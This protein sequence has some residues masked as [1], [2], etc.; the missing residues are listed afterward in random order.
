[1][2]RSNYHAS[3]RLG[4]ESLEGRQLMAFNPMG[5]VQ[6]SVNTLGDLIVTGDSNQNQIQIVAE[7]FNGVATPGKFFV[8]PQNGTTLNGQTEGQYFPGVTHDMRIN[9]G[10]ANDRLTLGFGGDNND[11]VVPNDLTIVMGEGNDVVNVDHIEVRDDVVINTGNGADNVTF[12]GTVGREP[13]VDSGNNDM[14]IDTGARADTVSLQNVFVRHDLGIQTGTDN[15]R[16]IVDMLFGNIGNNTAVNTG[17][18][19]DAVNIS[20]VGFNEKLTVN[21]GAGLDAVSLRNCEVD[22]FFADLGS[23]NDSLTMN[24][25]FGRRVSRMNGGTGADT[26]S[27]TGGGFTIPFTPQSF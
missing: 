3:R 21:T 13:G 18:G 6:V 1:M 11:F 14:K 4:L 16:D 19:N 7:M 8:A 24:N 23:G 15:Y 5:D 25:V 20:D 2:S 27:I 10:G 12:K 17:S 22:D 9:L 26:L